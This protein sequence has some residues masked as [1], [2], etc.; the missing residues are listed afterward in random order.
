MMLMVFSAIRVVAADGAAAGP[1]VSR[2]TEK[3]VE[4]LFR[5]AAGER[6]A[7]SAD[8]KFLAHTVHGNGELLIVVTDLERRVVTARISADEDRPILYSKEKRRAR[9]RF[10][11]WAEG[12]RLVFAP[13]IEVIA[14]PVANV[15]PVVNE[16]A[17]FAGGE[18]TTMVMPPGPTVIAPIMAIDADGKN[19]REIANT[20]SFQSMRIDPEPSR[21]SPRMRQKPSLIQ[22]FP[23]GVRTHLLVEI[24]G[25]E[26]W[27][28]VGDAAPTRI[29]RIDVRTGE[30]T[31]AHSESGSTELGL[32]RAGRP[33]LGIETGSGLRVDYKWLS[34]DSGR[35]TNLPVP[36]GSGAGASFTLTPETFF[37]ERAIPLGFDRD[38]A[39]LIY[40]TNFGR[41]TYGVFGLD[42]RTGLGSTLRLSHP[43]RDLVSPDA[44][45]GDEHLVIDRHKNQL[46]GVRAPG[47]RPFTVWIDAELA[48]VQA[49]LDSQFPR[50]TVELADWDAAR[51]RVLVRVSGGAEPGRIYEYQRET[52]LAVELTRATRAVAA[53]EWNDTRYIEFAGPGESRL[54]GFLTLPRNPRLTP[55]PLIIWLAPGLPARA[56]PE[57]DAQA[58]VLADMGFM[59][60]RVNQRGVAGMGRRHLEA[61]RADPDAATAEDALAAINWIAARHGIDRKRVV[62]W[63]EGVAGY[64]ALRAT[65]TLPEVFRC[66][67]VF[68]PVTNLQAWLRPIAE[69]P[70]EGMV[71]QGIQRVDGYSGI[72]ESVR[73]W[74]YVRPWLEPPA[75]AE[76]AVRHFLESVPGRRPVVSVTEDAERLSAATFVA[77]RGDQFGTSR[78]TNA[79]GVEQLRR[80]LRQRDIP[81]V[82]VKYDADFFAGLPKAR[83][84]LYRALEEFFHLHLDNFDVKIGPA[85]VVK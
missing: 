78:A 23:A 20:K 61:L 58:Q 48:E 74:T 44:R 82:L 32:D 42:L 70:A 57:Y 79:A 4:A 24:A 33:R 35:W 49:S 37:A 40:A 54:S 65:Q 72:G 76:E 73:I 7:L 43:E 16:V 50:R 51:K 64:F 52:G 6:V 62:V 30:I 2:V 75:F 56:H 14:P 41:D 22:G 8:G 36:P 85:R 84:Q 81:C 13:E 31:E 27:S 12:N 68:D 66:A 34:P 83:T 28:A 18:I 1:A 46:A 60:F 29:F 69:H 3:R 5:P 38:P 26:D 55:P 67:V 39:V 59:V 25:H 71:A 10:M 47:S 53:H 9:L 63:G 45:P 21:M 80:A 77:M 17:L 11:E 19:A 15:G